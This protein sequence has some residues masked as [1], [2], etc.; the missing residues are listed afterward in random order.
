MLNCWRQ[1]AYNFM[2][3]KLIVFLLFGILAV[4]TDEQSSIPLEAKEPV[5]ASVSTEPLQANESQNLEVKI[6]GV[7]QPKAL[8]RVLKPG[9]QKSKT[10]HKRAYKQSH[11]KT[12][13]KAKGKNVNRKAMSYKFGDSN[14]NE[15]AQ[16]IQAARQEVADK[17]KSRSHNFRKLLKSMNLDFHN[18]HLLDH[19][20]DKKL[21][22]QVRSLKSTI[23][24]VSPDLWIRK[25]PKFKAY[26]KKIKKKLENQITKQIK[27]YK[28]WR[29]LSWKKIEAVWKQKGMYYLR[30]DKLNREE[31]EKLYQL[32][33]IE[34]AD[35]LNF[36]LPMI[37]VE[38]RVVEMLERRMVDEDN[39]KYILLSIKLMTKQLF[40]EYLRR[41]KKYHS[42]H[43]KD[44]AKD[45]QAI[46]RQLMDSFKENEEF[47]LLAEVGA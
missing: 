11:K 8:P 39:E 19:I 25:N 40:L 17:K 7:D 38:K 32:F 28:S 33:L 47:N 9:K 6:D 2:D 29:K 46:D 35:K 31:H 34:D 3:W 14:L 16:K 41:Y 42:Q 37:D 1:L 21:A 30:D 20:T 36:L 15:T 10:K 27:N 44:F 4:R 45:L 23:E 5:T 22:N 43:R 26:A 13:K 12:V 18:F 24:K